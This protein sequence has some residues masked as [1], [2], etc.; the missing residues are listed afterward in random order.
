MVAPVYPLP[1]TPSGHL[2]ANGYRWLGAQ[3][4]K[5]MHRV[6]TTGQIFLPTHPVIATCQNTILAVTFA[7]P[8]PPL[9]WG[10]P[11]PSHPT[12]NVLNRGFVVQ[13]EGGS[14]SIVSVEIQDDDTVH[15]ELARPPQGQATLASASAATGGRGCLHDSD[16]AQSAARYHITPRLTG[17]FQTPAP[18][19][20]DGPYPLMNWCVASTI[21]IS[22]LR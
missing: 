13:D 21:R 16:N 7:V 18:T 14:V 15:I 17:G 20:E 10:N 19:L 8:V 6:L 9:A 12:D 11:F 3:F 2:D 4:G 5:V 1:H 22:G